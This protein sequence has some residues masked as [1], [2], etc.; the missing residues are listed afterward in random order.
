MR[1]ERT[2]VQPMISRGIIIKSPEFQKFVESKLNTKDIQISF[3]QWI[4]NVCTN[5]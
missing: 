4:S 2:K 1:F 5:I 3:R